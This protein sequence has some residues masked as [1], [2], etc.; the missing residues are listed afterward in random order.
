MF[1]SLS[2]V[3]PQR[4]SSL[5]FHALRPLVLG[6]LGGLCISTFGAAQKPSGIELFRD[7]AFKDVNLNGLQVRLG[8]PVEVTEQMGWSMTWAGHQRWTFVHETPILARFPHGELLATY[9][10][11]PDLQDDPVFSGAFQISNDGGLHWGRRYSVLMQHIPMTFIPSADNSLMA[12]PSEITPSKQ[13]DDRNFTGPLLT[14]KDGGK[15]MSM[16][17]EGFRVVDWPEPVDLLPSPQPRSNWH[18]DIFFTGSYLKLGSELLATVYWRAHGQKRM[19]LS[20]ASSKDGAHT[21]RYYS[22][23][24]TAESTQLDETQAHKPEGPDESSMVRLANGRLMIVFRVGGSKVWHLRRCF[25]DDNGKTWT[26]ADVLPAYS[27]EPELVQLQNGVIALTTGRPGLHLWV[28]GDPNAGVESWQD[29]DL[30]ERHNQWAADP[31]YM[32]KPRDP[33]KPDAGWTTTS[34]TGL[35][36]VAPGKLLLLYDRDP[37]GAPTSPSDLTRIFVMP[38]EVI[39]TATSRGPGKASK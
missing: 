24:A 26:K 27:V 38:I 34:Y 14:F 23:V 13:G 30:A 36:E 21:W 15:S 10:L 28:S 31:S 16:D 1:L 6:T 33:A 32:I 18:S 9:T 4:F 5:R 3:L 35:I 11:D 39:T 37:E 17:L 25:S 7:R 19:Q 22:T 2:N 8:D 29:V 20:L 12:L